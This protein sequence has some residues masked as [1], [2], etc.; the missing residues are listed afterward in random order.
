MFTNSIAIESSTKPEPTD[1]MD[2]TEPMTTKNEFTA[3]S[4]AQLNIGSGLDN[5]Q[6][7]KASINET[8]ETQQ[9]QMVRQYSPPPNEG[10]IVLKFLSNIYFIFVLYF[11]CRIP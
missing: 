11:D 5:G 10:H 6:I 4:D 1:R 8:V 3:I 7:Q 9:Q 2:V